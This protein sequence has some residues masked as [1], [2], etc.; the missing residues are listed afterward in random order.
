MSKIDLSK[1]LIFPS[2]I[3]GGLMVG[4]R[5]VI[6]NGSRVAIIPRGAVNT[7]RDPEPMD[8]PVV[9]AEKQD[10]HPAPVVVEASVNLPTKE[11]ILGILVARG[12][13]RAYYIGNVLNIPAWAHDIRADLS[14]KIKQ[15]L[16]SGDIRKVKDSGR[17]AKYEIV[18]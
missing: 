2:A 7:A 13:M 8:V 4:D 10:A 9:A 16:N 17:L 12:P 1:A 6:L 15:L 14:N 11:A 3:T 18:R 5:L